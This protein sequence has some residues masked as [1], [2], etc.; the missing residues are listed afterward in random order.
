M[1]KTKKETSSE[2]ER[3]DIDKD[4][5][6]KEIKSDVKEQLYGEVT[7][8]INYEVQNKLDKMEKKIYKYRKFSSFKRDIIILLFLC[9]IA[10]ESKILYNNGLLFGL[11]KA[12][13]NKVIEQEKIDNTVIKEEKSLDWYIDNY[14][15]LVDNIKTNL[16]DTTYLYNNIK[17]SDIDS[18]IKLNMA[19]QILDKQYKKLEDG[20]IRIDASKLKEAYEKIFTDDIK[21]SN[22]KDN[23]IQ[24]IY[25]KDSNN[26][27]AIDTECDNKEIIRS[28]YN[29]KEEDKLYIDILVGVL[30]GNTLTNVSG[31]VIKENYS[32]NDLESIQDKLEKFRFI[33]EKVDDKYYL[34]EI[35]R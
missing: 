10:Y 21:N 11:N 7:K 17:V 29:I 27:M 33:Y 19:Y 35:K 9:I 18:S 4:K 6:I 25:N 24:F 26:Y 31:Q 8:Q 1:S 32:N 15:Y 3:F 12:D 20:V 30:D 22:F 14:S 16:E 2:L 28:I 13:E 5:I 23:C 34:K